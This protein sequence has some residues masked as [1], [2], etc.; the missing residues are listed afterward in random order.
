MTTKLLQE[1]V[2]DGGIRSVNFFNG[3]LLT[4][5]DLSREQDARRQS[6]RRIAQAN[7]HGIAWGLEV[8]N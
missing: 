7:G 4:G 8:E 3:R 6:D 5:K 1:A 2:L